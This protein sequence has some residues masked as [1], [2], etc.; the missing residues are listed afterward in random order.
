MCKSNRYRNSFF[1][2]AI[3]SW[4]IFIKHFDGV[5][6]FFNIFK[7]YFNNCFRPKAKSIFS[8]HDPLGLCY[9]FQLRGRRHHFIDTPSDICHC[10]LTKIQL[11]SCSRVFSTQLREQPIV[12]LCVCVCVYAYV[13]MCVYVGVYVCIRMCVCVYT[14]VC[15]CVCVCAYVFIRRCVCTIRMCVCVFYFLFKSSFNSVIK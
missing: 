1:P 7:D 15:M 8:V 5:P 14:Y 13:C 4:D 12:L 10:N 2:G 6:S 11:I 3:V 9:L